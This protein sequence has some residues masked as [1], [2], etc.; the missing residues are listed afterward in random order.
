MAAPLSFAAFL[1]DREDNPVAVFLDAR[2]E[3]A[4]AAWEPEGAVP[5]LDSLIV[6]CGV[7]CFMVD[8]V[9]Q[10]HLVRREMI[11][12]VRTEKKPASMARLPRAEKRGANGMQAVLPYKGKYIVVTYAKKG[13]KISNGWWGKP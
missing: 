6:E 9:Q 8:E 2:S 10:T 1:L 4:T 13:G 12:S 11:L 3:A 7:D 5:M